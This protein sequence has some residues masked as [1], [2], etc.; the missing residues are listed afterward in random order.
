MSKKRR[1]A[2]LRSRDSLAKSVILRGLDALLGQ[3]IVIDVRCF[4]SE[5]ASLFLKGIV[6]V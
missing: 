4:R 5:K 6:S 1:R 3:P 2:R